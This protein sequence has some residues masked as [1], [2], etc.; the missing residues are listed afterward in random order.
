MVLQLSD[1]M[2][3]VDALEGSPAQCRALKMNEVESRRTG[4]NLSVF[5][6]SRLTIGVVLCAWI[7]HLQSRNNNH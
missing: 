5:P 7:A 6:T 4:L 3:F 2:V 1:K